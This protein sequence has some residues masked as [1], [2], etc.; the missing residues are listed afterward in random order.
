MKITLVLAL[1]LALLAVCNAA[2]SQYLRNARVGKDF[3]F[4]MLAI[5]WP[6]SATFKFNENVTT[7]TLHGTFTDYYYD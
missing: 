3:D 1:T 6:G 4:Y 7:W 2:S 5:Q